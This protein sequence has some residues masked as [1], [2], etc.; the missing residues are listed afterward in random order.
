MENHLC[1][2]Q[3][4]GRDQAV[5]AW[6]IVL[7]LALLFGA[8]ELLWPH[9]SLTTSDLDVAAVQPAINWKPSDDTDQTGQA[10]FRKSEGA[11]ER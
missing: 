1:E 9:A 8:L 7:V 6:G 10:G 3:R 11:F 4:S 2:R 5:C